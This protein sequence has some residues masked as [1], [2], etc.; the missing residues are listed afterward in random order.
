MRW[1][2]ALLIV[3]SLL[4]IGLGVYGFSAKD[5][6]PSLI[7]GGAAGFFMLGTV[8]LAQS[9]PR[10]GRIASLVIALAIL[11][12]FAPKFF[13]YKDWLPAG[14]MMIASAIVVIALIAGHVAGSRARKNVTPAGR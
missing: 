6:V 8:Y 2:N 4:S 1:L 11:G 3:F 12:Q 10:W 9:Q 7:G 14:T 13:K 5:S